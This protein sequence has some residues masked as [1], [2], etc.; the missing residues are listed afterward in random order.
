MTGAAGK[1]RVGILGGMGPEAT[2]LLMSRVIALTPASDDREHVPMLV[3]NNTQVPSRIEALIEKTGEDPGPVLVDMA[4]RLAAAGV[5]ALAMPCNTAH[6]YAPLLTE[7]VSIPLL[8]MVELSAEHVAR[9]ARSSGSAAS[10]RVGMLASPAVRIAGVFERAFA[11][12]GLQAI[13]PAQADRLLACIKTIKARGRNDAAI[14]MVRDVAAELRAA[15][16]DVLLVAC[17][18]LSLIADSLTREIPVVDTIDVLAD[19]VVA[20]SRGSAPGELLGALDT[21][22]ADGGRSTWRH[23]CQGG[24]LASPRGES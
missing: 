11:A 1:R 17:T 6:H 2:V 10:C 21:D 20:F 19:A 15:G 8:D 14:A 23:P 16:A 7:A 5:E 22:R 18:E 13:Y 4:R 12:R 24:A 3:D 9:L